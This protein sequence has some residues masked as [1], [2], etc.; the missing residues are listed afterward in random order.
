MAGMNHSCEKKKKGDGDSW[1]HGQEVGPLSLQT[2][3]P[4]TWY[5][6]IVLK[7]NG[8][9][10]TCMTQKRPATIDRSKHGPSLLPIAKLRKKG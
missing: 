8:H 10:I 3:K 1:V 6:R 5:R 9:A 2:R 7:R 4:L